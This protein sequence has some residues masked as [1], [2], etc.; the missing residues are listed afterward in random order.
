MLALSAVIV[1]WSFFGLG[2]PT[3]SRP[4]SISQASQTSTGEDNL[5]VSLANPKLTTAKIFYS[6]SG[7]TI[8]QINNGKDGLEMATSL[9]GNGVTAPILVSKDTKIVFVNNGKENPASEQDLKIGQT[10]RITL[11]Y[12]LKKKSWATATVK[13]VIK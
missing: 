8:K 2:A 11:S 4:Q 13:I 5:P 12:D 7:A 10:V 1:S 6:F 3:G 9:K